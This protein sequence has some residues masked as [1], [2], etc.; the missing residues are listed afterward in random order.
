MNFRQTTIFVLFLWVCTGLIGASG[1]QVN[2]YSARHY[3]NDADLYRLFTEKTGIEVNLVEGN[4]DAL[5]QRIRAEGRNSPADV[6]ITVDAGRLWMA[7]NE[8]FFQAIESAYLEEVVPAYLRHPDGLWFGITKRAR[9]LFYAKDRVNPEELSTY[10]DLADSKWRGRLLIRSSNNIY[11]QSL[12]GAMIEKLGEEGATEWAA[13]VHQNLARR[14]QSND[15][16]QIRAIAEGLGDVALANHYYYGRLQQS[17]QPA[18]QAIVEKVGV[19]YPNQG[20]G[21]A[22]VNISGV[23]VLANA[24]NREEAVAFLEFLVSPQAQ[25]ILISGNP[26]FPIHPEVSLPESLGFPD[27]E[28]DNVPASFIGANNGRAIRIFDRVGWR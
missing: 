19:F 21:G 23:G 6:F 10:E 3:S 13:Q 28:E 17:D 15:T 8:G 27:I 18:D 14:P 16:G 7:E 24:P 11:N 2:V 9:I 5:L 25:R 1:Q 26:E 22:H 4:G 12:L 20:K